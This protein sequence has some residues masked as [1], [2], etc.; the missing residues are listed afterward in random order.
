MLVTD[1]W[2]EQPGDWFFA[3]AKKADGGLISQGFS[4]LNFHRVRNFIDLHD[5]KNV[6]ACPH[7]FSKPIRR[8]IY[9]VEGRYLY[10][11]LDSVEPSSL[12]LRPTMALQ[13]SPGR[14][15]GLWRTDKTATKFLN[16]RL[17]HFVGADKG[18]W[19][20]T[21]LLRMFPGRRNYK[22]GDEPLVKLMWR[23]GPTHKINRL[24]ELIPELSDTVK[25]LPADYATS[26][27]LP[28]VTD[29]QGR[30][31]ARKFNLGMMYLGPCGDRSKAVFKIVQRV[32]LLGG[33]AE[34]A[35]AIVMIS[36]AAERYEG[37]RKRAWHDVLRISIKQPA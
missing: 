4:R 5:D 31:L 18:G 34:E 25:S 3:C 17:T 36:R 11:D 33:T 26:V 19:D 24:E 27:S 21:Q 7:G 35:F 13:S 8:A 1:I 30:Q 9:A 6:Y 29:K 10:A 14:Y 37:D 20:P 22:Y 28:S 16:Q 12:S 23:D 15:V 32:M 2:D